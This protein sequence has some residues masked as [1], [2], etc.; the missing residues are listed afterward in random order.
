MKVLRRLLCHAL[1][2]AFFPASPLAGQ[3]L[4]C[5]VC[6]FQV[7]GVVRLGAG[8]DSGGVFGDTQTIPRDSRQRYYV[9]KPGHSDR[10]FLYDRSGTFIRSI[11]QPEVKF[12]PI[13]L[14]QIG[15]GDS[16]HVFD[17]GLKRHFVFTPRLTVARFDTLPGSTTD[18]LFLE[19]SGMVLNSSVLTA[20]ALGFPAHYMVAGKIRK[21]FGAQSEE[22]RPDIA[23]MGWRVLSSA[24]KTSLWLINKTKPVLE[25]WTIDGKLAQ[26]FRLNLSWFREWDTGSRF[27]A[28]DAPKPLISAARTD[29][30]GRILIIVTVSNPDWKKTIVLKKDIDG[31]NAVPKDWDD[32]LD[33]YLLVVGGSFKKCGNK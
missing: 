31:T 11:G 29:T 9:L 7:E 3:I 19:K 32:A 8:K 20:A 17:N 15:P 5:T 2:I 23:Y 4:K 30:Y 12:D 25:R 1:G 33:S 10:I 28:A 14:I 13:N 27:S 21:S 6:D 24:N 16:L 26:A 22:Y 18:V